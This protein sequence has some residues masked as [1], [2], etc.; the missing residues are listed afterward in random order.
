[1]IVRI[2]VA[3]VAAFTNLCAAQ[4]QTPR[5]IRLLISHP[6]GGG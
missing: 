2:T 1:M 6:P 5:D 3:L 4:A